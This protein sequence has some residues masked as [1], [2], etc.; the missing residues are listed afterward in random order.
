VEAEGVLK[1][2]PGVGGQ[3][4]LGHAGVNELEILGFKAVDLSAHKGH[5]G[6]NQEY[7]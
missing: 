2:P 6:E 7:E 5:Y 4:L 1:A 3:K